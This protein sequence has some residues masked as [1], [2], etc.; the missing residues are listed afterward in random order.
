MPESITMDIPHKLGKMGSMRPGG[1]EVRHE[2]DRN[3]MKFTAAAMGQR[4]TCLTM[5]SLSS[6]CP[7]C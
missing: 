5:V 6:I 1:S 2:W 7:R 4:M 3:A